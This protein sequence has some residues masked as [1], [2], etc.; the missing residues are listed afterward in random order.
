[1]RIGDTVILEKAGDVIPD[2]VRVLI[3]LR[4]GKEKKFKWPTHI[5]ECGGDGSIERIPGEAAW[6]CVDKNSFAVQRRKF[7]HFASK[8]A[9]NIEG[10]GESTVDALLEKNLVGAY[11]DFFTLTEGDLL[12]LEGFAEV[13]AKKLIASIKKTA[14]HVELARLLAGLSIPHVGEET[15]FL[16]AEKFK[17]LDDLAQAKEAELSNIK[18]IGEVVG[19]SIALWFKDAENK[20]L[21][22]RLKKV[23]LIENKEYKKPGEKLPLEGK[24]FV[25]TGTLEH[26]SRDEAKQKLR[27]LGADVSSSVSKNTF[28]V[29][30]GEEAGSKL[31]RAEEL[32]VTILDEKQFE[33]LLQKHSA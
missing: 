15:A 29:V 33:A 14:E 25:L 31:D 30:A 12:T 24:T 2:I 10:L 8:G 23:I 1:V 22:T 32:G 21:I 20:K 19:R 4:T 7:R 6:R 18:G 17:T 28:A 27:A 16:L 3:E 5:M 13:S 11:D 26:F 9:L